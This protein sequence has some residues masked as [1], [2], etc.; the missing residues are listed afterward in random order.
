MI[1]SNFDDKN[2]KNDILSSNASITD[3]KEKTETSD[4]INSRY[5]N[6]ISD[7]A[8]SESKE[9][10]ESK[11]KNSNDNDIHYNYAYDNN[12]MD[13]LMHHNGTINDFN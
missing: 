9:H 13:M 3:N 5:Y 11:E 6:R 8:S 10:S 1:A 2:K 7:D 12:P 4:K